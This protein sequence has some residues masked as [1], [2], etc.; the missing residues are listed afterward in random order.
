[1]NI[2]ELEKAAQDVHDVVI[3]IYTEDRLKVNDSKTNILQVESNTGDAD[4]DDRR[5]VAKKGE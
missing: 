1:M 2:S 5:L 3:N 4:N